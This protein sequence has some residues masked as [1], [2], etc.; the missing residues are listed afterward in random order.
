MQNVLCTEGAGAL[1]IAL[2]HHGYATPAALTGGLQLALWVCGLTGLLAAPAAVLL[3]RRTERPNAVSI[4]RA[5]EVA[6][7]MVGE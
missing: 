6:M 5:P 1:G 2:I 4:P 3:I 7:A